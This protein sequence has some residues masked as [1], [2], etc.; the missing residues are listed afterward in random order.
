MDLA[1]K[2]NCSNQQGVTS[3]P[4]VV[5]GDYHVKECDQPEQPKNKLMFLQECP[6]TCS[7]RLRLLVR[8]YSIP[9]QSAGKWQL[10]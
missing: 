3:M 2:K 9:M 4:I 10:Q 1:C 7:A 8:R 5:L 6:H